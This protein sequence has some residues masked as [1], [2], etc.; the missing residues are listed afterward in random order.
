MKDI[1][2]FTLEESEGIGAALEAAGVEFERNGVITSANRYGGGT[3][4]V[5][6]VD[7]RDFPNAINTIKSYYG[8][9][10]A[11]A[12][13]VSGI[14]PACGATVNNAFECPDCGLSLS[15]DSRDLMK[16]HPFTVFLDNLEKNGG[17]AK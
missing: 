13:A 6:C 5:F 7:D 8:F 4:F 17:L 9:L 3:A 12:E 1:S 2:Q 11:P 15:F 14:C 10:D 16:N